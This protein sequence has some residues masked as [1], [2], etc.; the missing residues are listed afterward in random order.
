MKLLLGV[1]LMRAVELRNG[2]PKELTGSR[3]R[4]EEIDIELN[5]KLVGDILR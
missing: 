2:F 1:R 5:R 4:H 3:K